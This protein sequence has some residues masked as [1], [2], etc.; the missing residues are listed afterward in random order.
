MKVQELLNEVGKKIFM[1]DDKLS[2]PHFFFLIN[3]TLYIRFF[4]KSALILLKLFFLSPFCVR[5]YDIYHKD[6]TDDRNGIKE[7]FSR[8][9]SQYIEI[10][11]LRT[12]I[13][14]ISYSH[15]SSLG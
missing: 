10:N 6:N 9:S 14:I 4:L 12:I 1:T 15:F 5:M 7:I 11:Q 3:L 8:F 13:H 2:I